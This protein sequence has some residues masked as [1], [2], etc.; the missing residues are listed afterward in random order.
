MSP[1]SD[2]TPSGR[3]ASGMT[4]A[5]VLRTQSLDELKA[6]TMDAVRARPSDARERW[7]L[8]QLLCIE[9]DWDRALRQIATW[10]T[11]DPSGEPR[12]QLYRGLIA[13][14]MFRT[15]VF[16]GIRRP[17]FIDTP[18]DWV[19]T[20]LQANAQLGL[21]EI[22][23]ADQLRRAAFDASQT[24]SGSGAE[25]GTFAWIADSDTRLGPV[26][27]LA[28]AGGYRWI[29]FAQMRSL[30][31]TPAAAPSDLVWRQA[32]VVLSDA[33]VLRGYVPTRYPGSQSGPAAIRLAAETCWA[34][35]GDTNVIAHG[36]KTWTTDQ[37]DWGLM[38]L[39]QCTFVNGQDDDAAS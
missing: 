26:C 4:L 11:L 18:P 33:T 1:L 39:S 17:G 6:Q 23:A 14:E 37:G 15:E 34:D 30:S 38:Q 12:A 2:P 32:T 10:A 25:L 36:Q 31:F 5:Q 22:G 8:C 9:G 28:V 16:A 13:S 19:E 27:E 21:G 24:A 35:V 7:L 3:S 20:L 29:P